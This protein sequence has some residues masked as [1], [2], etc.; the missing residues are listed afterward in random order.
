MALDFNENII[1]KNLNKK[2]RLAAVLISITFCF[3]VFRLYYLQILKGS[4]FTELSTNNRIRITTLP[5]PR[6]II[7]SKNRDVLV[8]NI[9]SFDLNLI[10]QD[11]PDHNKVLE[12][13]SALLCIDR[14]VLQK[15]Y[16]SQRGRPPFEPVTLKK[17][18]SWNEMSLVLSQKLDLPGISIDVVPKRLYCGD[19][20]APHV[21]GFLGEVDRNEL[22]KHVQD[23]YILGDLIGKFGLEKWGEQYLHGRRGGLKSEVDAYGNRQKILAEIEPVAGCN[24]TVSL[25]PQLQ[26]AAEEALQEKTGAIVAMNPYSGEIF[27]L[28]SKPCF[29]SNLFSRGIDSK[30]WEK[31]I[32]NPLHPLLN[33]AIQTQQPPGSV[34]KIITAIAALEEKAVDPNTKIFCPGYLSLGSRSFGCWKK[35]GHGLMNMHDAIVQSCDVYFYTVGLRVGIDAINKY[36]RMFGLGDKTG[37]EIEGEKEGLI[38]SQEWKKKRFGYPWQK[39]E[40]LNT[41]IGQGFVLCTPLQIACFF[42]GLANGSYIP[43]PRIIDSV[44]CG[45]KQMA[46]RSKKIKTIAVSPE[47]ISLIREALSGVVQEPAGTASKAKINNVTVGGK[48]GTAQVISKKSFMEKAIKTPW[49]Y[50][51]HAWFAAFAPVEKPEI[52]VSVFVEHGGH[53]GSAA[54]PLAKKI[55]EAYFCIIE[56]KAV[57]NIIVDEQAEED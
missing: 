1:E 55:L 51:D 15:K 25:L 45:N 34:F 22:K 46:F 2:I 42:C 43:Q 35:H 30:E 57:E 18:L 44:D 28:A 6:G 54:A 52:V 49:I 19:S 27:A 5:A 4:K 24:I 48:T 11:T 10:P 37:I 56:K 38:P 7:L 29:D 16:D 47:T 20:F 32:K 26:K 31:L 13:L 21:F 9:P 3:I 36:A 50:E 39:G 40:T 23:D 12:D 8:T 14:S 53:G 17:E 41:S 33:R